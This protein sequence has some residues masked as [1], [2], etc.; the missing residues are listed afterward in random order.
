MGR[1]EKKKGESGRAASLVSSCFPPRRRERRGRGEKGKEKNGF[2][3]APGSRKRK[4]LL[5]KR[6]KGGREKGEIAVL[7]GRDLR[8]VQKSGCFGGRKEEKGEKIRKRGGRKRAI[9]SCS[10]GL[11]SWGGG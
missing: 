1:G 4:N 7:S 10:S 11:L 3:A 6:R 8:S 2:F 5:E 9:G